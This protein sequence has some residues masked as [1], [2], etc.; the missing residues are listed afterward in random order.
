M[1]LEETSIGD[2]P[3][4]L[5]PLRIP[6]D[7]KPPGVVI[8]KGRSVPISH[9]GVRGMGGRISPL[10]QFDVCAGRIGVD[11][12]VTATVGG[13]N[14]TDGAGGALNEVPLGEAPAP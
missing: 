8:C 14:A 11:A 1:K 9:L 10:F 6:L 3:A 2:A 4:V 13:G 7:A 5:G 12:A